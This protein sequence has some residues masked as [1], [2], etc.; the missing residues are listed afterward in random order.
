MANASDDP[1]G[2]L[3]PQVAVLFG[4]MSAGRA[5]RVLEAPALR[6]GFDALVPLLAADAPPV[7]REEVLRIPGADGSELRALLFAPEGESPTPRPLVL[8]LHGGGWVIMSPDSH[9]KLTKQLCVGA[10]AIVVSLDYRMSPE[11][12]FPAPLDDCVAAWRWLRDHAGELGADPARMALAGDSAGGN[13]TATTT[14][15]LLANG[16]VPPRANLMLCPVTDVH[17]ATDSYRAFAPDDPV[18]DAAIMEFF[19]DSYVS[20]EQW[21][22]PF[23]S[24]LRA[25]LE[26]FPPTCVLAAGIDPLCDDGTRFVDA[27]R[28]AGAEATLHRYEGMPHV[29]MLFPGIDAGPQSLQDGAEFLRAQL[30]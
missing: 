3:D 10:D 23:V 22:D 19:R 8:Y 13:L 25:N 14:L 11:H 17:F 9:A 7:A 2:T 15:R 12:P 27:L 6:A 16:E 28:A 30:A 5:D 18:L 24:P 21:D 20:R 4:M 1:R 29:F 26:G